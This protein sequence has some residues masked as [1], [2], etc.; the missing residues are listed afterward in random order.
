MLKVFE[1]GKSINDEKLRETNSEQ[2]NI[3]QK[4]MTYK[5]KSFTFPLDPKQTFFQEEN[6]TKNTNLNISE[7]GRLENYLSM[8][9][10]SINSFEFEEIKQTDLFSQYK[11]SFF[12]FKKILG[13][14][15]LEDPESLQKKIEIKMINYCENPNEAGF[16]ERKTKNSIDIKNFSPK[17]NSLKEIFKEQS[18]LVDE[19][20]QLL[21]LKNSF[22]LLFDKKVDS[23]SIE[24]YEQNILNFGGNVYKMSLLMYA[25][26]ATIFLWQIF[27][28]GNRSKAYVY[29]LIGRIMHILTPLV[30]MKFYKF[31]LTNHKKKMLLVIFMQYI[32][33]LVFLF[34]DTDWS[35]NFVYLLEG[36]F[37]LNT[38]LILHNIYF[39]EAFIFVVV[40]CFV[41]VSFIIYHDITNILYW[42]EF[43]F[44]L[45]NCIFLLFKIR[46]KHARCIQQF[47]TLKTNLHHKKKQENLITYLLPP[48]IFLAFTQNKTQTVDNLDDV[49]ILFADIAGFTKYSSSVSALEVLSMLRQLFT[50]FDKLCLNYKIYKLYTIG[51]CYVI[52]GVLDINYRDPILE[53]F[54]VLMAGFDMINIIA[55]VKKKINFSDLNMRIGIHTV[56][57]IL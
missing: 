7:K 35:T 42:V 38:F 29:M 30:V 49:T 31:F 9:S 10:G 52:M 27:L 20:I 50:E 5:E 55:N 36:I 33:F 25:I 12:R 17:K 39:V 26:I 32:Y 43:M 40:L 1:I 37:Y 11:T 46:E 18:S 48:H 41:F 14:E 45:S 6:K 8:N 53:L 4:M 24:D 57:L 54:K 51:D 3:F 34:D 2:E 13:N 23:F 44:T 28:S 15:L 21:T 47:N 22:F 16:Q 19:K 56:N